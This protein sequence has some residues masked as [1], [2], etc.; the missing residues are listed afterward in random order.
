MLTA[1]KHYWGFVTGRPCIEYPVVVGVAGAVIA[2]VKDIAQEDDVSEI[3][4]EAWERM[5]HAGMTVEIDETTAGE[6]RNPWGIERFRDPP[7]RGGF[8]VAWC[9]RSVHT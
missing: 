3:A 8:Y 4:F 2:W 1:R 9:D 5:T 7:P 6:L